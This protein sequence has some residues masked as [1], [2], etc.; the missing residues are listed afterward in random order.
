MNEFEIDWSAEARRSLAEVIL[1]IA[2]QNPAAAERWLGRVEQTVELLKATPGIGV[3]FTES[4]EI[5]VREFVV[6]RYRVFY[7]VKRRQ[8]IVRILLIWHSARQQPDEKQ[9]GLSGS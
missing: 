4:N 3:R 6:G 1:Y 7:Q 5:E 2:E 9:L 8:F